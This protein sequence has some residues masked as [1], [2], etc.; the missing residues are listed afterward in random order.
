MKK[1]LLA[2]AVSAAVMLAMSGC[3]F[4]EMLGQLDSALES[5]SKADSS[6]A[7]DGSTDD[8]PD[9]HGTD[10]HRSDSQ[11]P[12]KPESSS[13]TENDSTSSAE[14]LGEVDEVRFTANAKAV[15]TSYFSLMGAAQYTDAFRLCTDDFLAKHYPQGLTD[16]ENA[17]PVSVEFCDGSEFFDTDELG[18]SRERITVSIAKQSKEDSAFDCYMYVVVSGDHFLI[19]E[20][21]KVGD[22]PADNGGLTENDVDLFA[23]YV[24]DC[25]NI[26]LNLLE[27]GVY[28]TGDGS[29]LDKLIPEYT[30]G[31]HYLVTIGNDGVES[32]VYTVDGLTAVYPPQGE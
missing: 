9:D 16:G 5:V 11:P 23:R 19:S 20:T 6:S 10:K 15:I 13:E 3:A 14:P 32:V 30:P 2:A 25:T 24:F 29:E 21:E 22:D 1:R 12:V 28:E 31:G 17:S 26:Y 7:E 27:P 4:E 8:K 18:R